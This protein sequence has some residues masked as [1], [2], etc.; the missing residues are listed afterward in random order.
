MGPA[1]EVEELSESELDGSLDGVSLAEDVDVGVVSAG[2]VVDWDVSVEDEVESVDVD[3]DVVVP[4][5]F[6]EVSSSPSP[7]A[8][9]KDSKSLD[10]TWSQTVGGE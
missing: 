1:D 2:V 4:V 10:E 3:V 7:S 9:R 5:V 6:V 8:T